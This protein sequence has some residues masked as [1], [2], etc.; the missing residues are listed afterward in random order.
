MASSSSVVNWG[1]N[2]TSL[3]VSTDRFGLSRPQGSNFDIGAH[4]LLYEPPTI[5][6]MLNSDNPVSEL[7]VFPSISESRITVKMPPSVKTAFYRVV[8]A[9]GQVVM[10]NFYSDDRGNAFNLDISYLKRGLYVLSLSD[11]NIQY[12]VKFIR[13]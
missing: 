7:T 2:L 13:K 5:P 4:E 6:A 3:G 11:N 1:V 8:N 10:N 12:N 9:Q